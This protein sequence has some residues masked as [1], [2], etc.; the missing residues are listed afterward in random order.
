MSWSLNC[1]YYIFPWNRPRGNLKFK[2]K[3]IIWKC[4][5]PLFCVPVCLYILF[6]CLYNK[7]GWHEHASVCVMQN[8]GDAKCACCKIKHGVHT[9]LFKLLIFWL[10]KAEIIQKTATKVCNMQWELGCL[11]GKDSNTEDLYNKGKIYETTRKHEKSLFH[12]EVRFCHC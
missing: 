3:C 10:V 1:F 9:P 8:V 11:K 4:A 2:W 7:V 5:S 12:A 6:G